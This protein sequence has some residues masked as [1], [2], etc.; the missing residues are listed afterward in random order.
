MRGR[1][2]EISRDD[3]VKGYEIS[4]DH[5]VVFEKDEIKKLAARKKSEYRDFEFC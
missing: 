2:E 3:I 1:K 4:P 5:Y